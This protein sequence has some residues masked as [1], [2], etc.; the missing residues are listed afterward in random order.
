[1]MRLL[2]AAYVP[3]ERQRARGREQSFTRPSCYGRFVPPAVSRR[4]I[5]ATPRGTGLEIKELLQLLLSLSGNQ[6]VVGLGRVI[7]SSMKSGTVDPAG[8]TQRQ[9][10]NHKGT[11]F[12]V[13]MAPDLL[14]RV[15]VHS[16]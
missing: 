3:G 12:F 7:R 9:I 1:M 10:N 11:I 5:F 13:A 4:S 16:F 15:R 14:S 8:Q 2:I 6:V